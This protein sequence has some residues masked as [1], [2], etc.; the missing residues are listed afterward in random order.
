LVF[1][2][3]GLLPQTGGATPRSGLNRREKDEERRKELN[4]LR[5]EARAKRSL[6]AVCW[7]LFLVGPS[8]E[9][10]LFQK[11]SFDLQGQTE[12]IARFEERLRRGQSSA[13]YPNF[14]AA[15]WRE[16]WERE[17]KRLELERIWTDPNW[18]P[19]SREEGEMN[20]GDP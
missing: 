12:K 1:I 7:F 4:K 16:L 5:D 2:L 20:D 10:H 14:L 9:T 6:E 17:K 18:T 8:T 19:E 15:K 3:N 11:Q 13:L